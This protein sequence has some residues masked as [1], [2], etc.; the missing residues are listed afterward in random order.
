MFRRLTKIC[1]PQSDASSKDFRISGAIFMAFALPLAGV[2]FATLMS[3]GQMPLIS[4]LL[5]PSIIL[6]LTGMHRV[7]WGG[8]TA[9]NQWLSIGRVVI[10]AVIGFVSLGVVSGLTGAVIGLIKRAA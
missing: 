1:F 8:A 2:I 3:L 7:L 5:L 6:W 4:I 10:T 9:P